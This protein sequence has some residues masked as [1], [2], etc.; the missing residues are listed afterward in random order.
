MTNVKVR[1]ILEVFFYIV[2]L[3]FSKLSF[4]SFSDEHIKTLKN[5][6]IAIVSGNK[7]EIEE[8]IISEE[9]FKDKKN[10]KHGVNH[11]TGFYYSENSKLPKQI[12]TNFHVIENVLTDSGNVVFGCQKYKETYK[13]FP[14]K[15]L[16]IDKKQDL[17]LLQSEN[18]PCM[19]NLILTNDFSETAN[20]STYGNKF[21]LGLSFLSGIV[22]S[23]TNKINE[24]AEETY[25]FIDINANY[26]NSGG[27]ILIRNTNKV[28]GA[29]KSIYNSRGHNNGAGISLVITSENIVKSLER[30]E[31]ILQFEKNFDF[32]IEQIDEAFILIPSEQKFL[33]S[34]E[35]ETYEELQYIGKQSIKTKLQA[36][37]LL[38]EFIESDRK[39]I[40]IVLS[41]KKKLKSVK[42]KKLNLD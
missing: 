31:S 26:G 7:S 2:F 42:L 5:C 14:L 34:F 19:E 11:G 21:G 1:K 38:Y 41:T 22:S 12:I 24:K 28:I 15:L 30:M 18:M 8:S 23:K 40:N 13:C 32:K 4:A 37:Y 16:M 17:S 20:V 9:L 39:E 10:N 36:I 29:F 6:V 25:H 35:I 3:F 33:Q 27:P